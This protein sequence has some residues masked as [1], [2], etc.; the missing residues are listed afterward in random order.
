MMEY[1]TMGQTFVYCT[2]ALS[3]HKPRVARGSYG[4]DPAQWARRS[5]TDDLSAGA[6]RLMLDQGKTVAAAARDLG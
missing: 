4:L 6:V 2:V 3:S 5:F 1:S